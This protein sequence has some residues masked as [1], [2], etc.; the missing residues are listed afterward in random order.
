MNSM[1][2]PQALPALMRFGAQMYP[3]CKGNPLRIINGVVHVCALGAAWIAQRPHMIITPQTIELVNLYQMFEDLGIDRYLPVQHPETSVW[4][5]LIAI[6]IQ[7]NDRTQDP[8][9]IFKIADWLDT[10]DLTTG[11]PKQQTTKE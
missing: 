11:K 3:Q 8:W 6:I 1:T 9:S 7:L 5:E 2:R 4:G 10:I